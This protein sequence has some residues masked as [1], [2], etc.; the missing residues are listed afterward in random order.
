[1]LMPFRS[2]EA[3]GSPQKARGGRGVFHINRS[4][5][6][7]DEAHMNSERGRSQPSVGGLFQWMVFRELSN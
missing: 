2:V 6:W 5:W 4:Q 7:I 3:P 1:M